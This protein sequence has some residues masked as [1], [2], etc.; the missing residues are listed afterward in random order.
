MTNEIVLEEP[1]M[2]SSIDIG[3]NQTEVSACISMSQKCSNEHDKLLE[4]TL[5]SMLLHSY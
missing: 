3:W 4:S 5:E 2:I 1:D